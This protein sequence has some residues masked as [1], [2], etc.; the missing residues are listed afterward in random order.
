M[1]DLEIAKKRLKE[2]ALSLCIVKK[3]KILFESDSEGIGDLVQAID[4]LGY[5]LNKASVADSIVGKAAALLCIYSKFGSVFAV[6]ISEEALKVLKMNNVFTEFENLVPNILNKNKTDICPFE[7]MVLNCN[8]A[9][10]ALGMFKS[11]LRRKT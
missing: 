7:K 11:F 10:Q 2:N 4:E 9:E 8:D 3:G 1:K 5:T 6:T